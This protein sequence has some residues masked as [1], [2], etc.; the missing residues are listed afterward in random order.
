MSQPQQDQPDDAKGDPRDAPKSREQLLAE[1]ASL[2]AEVA[3]LQQTTGI[4]L[5]QQMER[6]RLIT[7]IVQQM[8]ETLDLS[9][10][11]NTTVTELRRFLQADRVLIYQIVAQIVADQRS[12]VI[13]EAVAPAWNSL[14][15][16]A[17]AETCP[18]ETRPRHIRGY[19]YRVSDR[20]QADMPVC[21]RA[22]LEQIQVRAELLVPIVQQETLW[23]LLIVHQ[24]SCPREWQS[25]ESQLLEQLAD[26]LAGAIQQSV[27]YQQLQ[28]EL[29]ERQQI[30]V[31]LRQSEAEFRLLSDNSPIGIL[32][33]DAQG[34]CTYTNPRYQSICDCTLEA[35]LGYGWL[36]LLHPE[37]RAAIA[38]QWAMAVSQSQTYVHEIRY[39]QQDGSIRYC[40]LHA[41]PLFDPG[42]KFIGHVGTVEDITAARAVAQMKNE[43]ISVVS[44]ELR[45]PLTALRGSL[46]MLANGVYD[47]K[48]AKGKR[49]LQIAAESADRLARLVSDI[50]DLERLES[51]KITLIQQ[52]CDAGG[53]M[54][55]A[56]E[57][58][59]TIAN[60]DRITLS[61]ELLNVNVW[62]APDSIIQT[63]INLLSNAIKFSEPGSTVW[64]SATLIE[65]PAGVEPHSTVA[66]GFQCAEPTAPQAYVRFSVKDQG[67]GI[68]ADKLET[69][70]GQFQQVDASD[71]R[72]KGGTGLGLAICRSIV[73]QHGGKIWAESL[74]GE[75]STFYFTLPLPPIQ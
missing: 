60:Q 40:Q 28:A 36:W 72:Q 17:Y 50:L 68:P 64:L 51:G 52:P 26:Q 48:P 5:Q 49:M 29:Q 46:G 42:G 30:E 57:A 47:H 43:F 14:L 39:V 55:Q 75:G 66:L 61:T 21:R 34:L 35:A 23:G 65:A 62:A 19:V 41:A 25:W 54:L 2:R 6:E 59:Q 31:A 69:I 32:R 22:F 53:L 9:E 27:L 38:D 16:F 13:A 3:A 33:T 11:L 45:T 67:R 8:R 4:A 73:Q 18:V 70:F 74:I 20:D 24:C 10:I 44:H 37:D 1:L 63:L 71:S 12:R 15:D 7:A 58:L 56:I